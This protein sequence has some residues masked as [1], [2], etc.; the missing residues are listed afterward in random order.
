MR[1]RSGWPEKTILYRS[2]APAFP[3]QVATGQIA[4]TD[5]TAGGAGRGDHAQS[6][7]PNDPRRQTARP[8]GVSG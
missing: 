3:L 8:F 1:R 5:G 4:W 2:H 7:I 6:V